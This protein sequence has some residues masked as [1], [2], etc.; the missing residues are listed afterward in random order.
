MADLA[1]QGPLQLT[2]SLLYAKIPVALISIQFNNIDDRM[3]SDGTSAQHG[4]G[5]SGL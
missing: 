2:L 1:L 5:R 4:S 3:I